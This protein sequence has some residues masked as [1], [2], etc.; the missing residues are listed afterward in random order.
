MYDKYKSSIVSIIAT[1]IFAALVIAAC[2][3]LPF[4]VKMYL[5][6]AYET[7]AGIKTALYICLYISGA[8]SLMISYLLL[9]VLFNIR[10][11][12]VFDR[13]NVKYTRYISWCCF[14]VCAAFFALGFF[15]R[16]SFVI[17]FAA[18]FIGLIVRVVKNLLNEAVDIKE[19]NDLTV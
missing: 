6:D 5:G 17:S 12:I 4:F 9:R 15:I 3:L 16:F 1:F 10:K 2:V 11:N 14:V 7:A 8:S 18:A 13:R 19:E